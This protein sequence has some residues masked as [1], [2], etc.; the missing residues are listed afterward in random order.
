MSYVLQPKIILATDLCFSG[1]PNPLDQTYTQLRC[2]VDSSNRETNSP[3]LQLNSSAG[4]DDLQS[5][6]DV[7]YTAGSNALHSIG[8]T[9][10]SDQSSGYHSGNIR[11]TARCLFLHVD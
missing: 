8:G 6:L 2:P 9:P 1:I 11:G 5:M 10:Q 7:N 4:R 3:F